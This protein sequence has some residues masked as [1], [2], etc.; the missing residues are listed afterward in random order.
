MELQ[1][2]EQVIKLA[3]KK[4]KILDE[5]FIK[6][7]IRAALSGIYIG[8]GIMLSFRLGEGF[9]DIHSPVAS[10]LTSI[11]FGIALV[12][13][14]YGGSELFTGNT[15]YFTVST[16]NKQ[17]SWKDT[18]QNWIACYTGNLIG[19]IFFALLV[20]YS[21]IF[22]S[23]DNSQLLMETAAHKMEYSTM[24]LFF[25][26]I[27]CNWVVCLAVWIPMHVKG[28]GGK[29]AVMMLLVFVFVASGFEHSV[30]NMVTFSL[31]LILPHPETITLASAFH[32][33]IPVTIGN[34]IG[35]GLFVGGTYVFLST[36][37]NQKH[38]L[39]LTKKVT[40]KPSYL[41]K[42]KA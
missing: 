19:A 29:I 35:G 23:L 6:Y 8:F 9:F 38:Q 12:L 15:M 36:T 18:F 37:S 16:L 21:G 13:I 17:T 41:K 2:M 20:L 40:A 30:A 7:L 4:K 24:E 10:M 34:I 14:I 31:A 33:L 32:N 25:R 42:A 26:A 27:L 1:P 11:F 28:D 3:L 22:S 5:S 39:K